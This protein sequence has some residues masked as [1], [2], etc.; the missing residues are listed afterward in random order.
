MSRSHQDVVNQG[1]LEVSDRALFDQWDKAKAV[2]NGGLDPRMGTTKKNESCPT[3]NEPLLLCNGHY[4][5]VKL[6]LPVFHIGYFKKTISILQQ[7][8]K[9]CS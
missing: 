6:T 9:V 4:G 8:C 7:I 1:V 2:T 5:Y 3:C